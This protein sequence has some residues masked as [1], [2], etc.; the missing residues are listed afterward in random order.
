MCMILR[1]LEA[2]AAQIIIGNYSII[3]I[4]IQRSPSRNF[5]QFLNQL[6]FILKY[7]HE[8][9]GDLNVDFLTDSNLN[10]QITLLLQS[11]IT[12]H[13]ID[14][15]TRTTKNFSSAIGNICI[16]YCRVNFYDMFALING[17]FDHDVPYLILNKVFDSQRVISYQLKK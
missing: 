1:V 13:T 9:S 15:P 4:C 16:D 14:F 5:Y 10:L 7:L 6:N 17:L 2:C 8:P 11:Y 12:F 3:I